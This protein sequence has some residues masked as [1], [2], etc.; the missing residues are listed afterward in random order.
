MAT[1]VWPFV[2]IYSWGVSL[3]G[4]GG[5]YNFYLLDTPGGV[6]VTYHKRFLCVLVLISYTYQIWVQSDHSR[7]W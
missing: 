2:C 7:I 3:T 6:S 5:Q 1:I 4:S